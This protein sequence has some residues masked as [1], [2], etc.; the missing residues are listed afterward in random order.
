MALLSIDIDSIIVRDMR[1]LGIP[2][3]ISLIPIRTITSL[4]AGIYVAG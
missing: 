4:L 3:Y 2:V 1:F